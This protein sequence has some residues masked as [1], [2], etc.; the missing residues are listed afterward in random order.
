MRP[1]DCATVRGCRV[2]PPE[3]PEQPWYQRTRS[4][5]FSTQLPQCNLSNSHMQ[6]KRVSYGCSGLL[7]AIGGEWT[8]DTLLWPCLLPSVGREP[9]LSLFLSLSPS[10]T[11]QAL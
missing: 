11:A 1:C 9:A 2:E 3:L 6:I 8:F 4:A 10:S 5:P 7:T